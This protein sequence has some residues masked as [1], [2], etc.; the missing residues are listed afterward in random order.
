MTLTIPVRAVAEYSID[1][2]LDLRPFTFKFKWNY[3]GQYWTL[4][5]WTRED[6]LIHGGV[7]IVPSYDLLL[8]MRHI[9]AL[10]QGAL[11]VIDTTKTADA[12]VFADLGERLLLS[13]IPEAD[14]AE[15]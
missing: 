6:V 9:A 12:I 10:P 2:D 1:L 3:R 14:I 15:L 5:F 11:V 13:Y 7:K 8:N 4:E